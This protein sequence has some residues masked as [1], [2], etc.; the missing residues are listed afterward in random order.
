MVNFDRLELAHRDTNR[1][2]SGHRLER[3]KLLRLLR[4]CDTTAARCDLSFYLRSFFFYKIP[5]GLLDTTV[6]MSA[7][8]TIILPLSTLLR[9]PP[10]LEM[11]QSLRDAKAHDKHFLQA[12]HTMYIHV[13]QSQT[14]SLKSLPG[15][16][17]TVYFYILFALLIRWLS[18]NYQLPQDRLFRAVSFGLAVL[19]IP[20]SAV[21]VTF[22]FYFLYAFL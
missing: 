7:V 13:G 19:L 20:V 16:I 1:Q 11:L 2:D 8:F 14:L 6:W 10:L 12:I 3:R 21:P 4:F 17:S 15:T 5:I 22:Y 9:L 18:A